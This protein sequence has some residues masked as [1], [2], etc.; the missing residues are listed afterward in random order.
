LVDILT[1]RHDALVV[2]KR[3]AAALTRAIDELL[4]QPADARKL[5]ENARRTGARYDIGAF[6]RKM[7]RLYEIVHDTSRRTRRAGVLQADLSFLDARG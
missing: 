3:D 4:D 6:V 7:E 1:D 5:A 2:P